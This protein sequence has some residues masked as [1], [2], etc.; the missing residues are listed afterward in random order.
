M[1][2]DTAAIRQSV[3]ISRPE[4]ITVVRVAGEAAFAALDR[5]LPRELYLRDG[6]ILHTLL[7]AED[8][9]PLCDL[10]VCRTDEAYL[11][12]AEGMSGAGVVEH[13]RSHAPP[14]AALDVRSLDETHGLVSVDG[15]YAW[16]LLA[17]ALGPDVIGLPYLG[18][19]P[20]PDFTCLRSGKTGEY[21]YLLLGER[22]QLP[23]LWARLCE[24]GA[25][26]DVAEAS[27]AAL[28]QCALENAFFNIRREGSLGLGPLELQLQWRVSY[29]KDFA[30]TEALRLRRARG[31][32]ARLT[33]MVS[34]A[35]LAAGDALGME[36]RAVGKVVNAGHSSTRGDFVGLGLIDLG[37]AHPGLTLRVGNGPA[38]A[39]TVSTPVINNRSLYVHPQ[40]H[41][42][43]TREQHAFP[44]VFR[45]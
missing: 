4:H 2:V 37:F 21:G 33:A 29:Q 13:V 16:E 43:R 24:R 7:L 27:L 30:G 36:G 8:A 17:E 6:Q 22:A 26:L 40:R 20:L 9:T 41:S 11:L 34:A 12:V 39:R 25:A 45:P 3:A 23:G 32:T 14:G 5:V 44:P 1:P 28:D 38:T 42:Y 19:F 18:L 35:P 31:A 15:P 10:M